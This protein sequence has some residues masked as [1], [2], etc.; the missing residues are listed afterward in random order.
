MVQT[1]S[2]PISIFRFGKVGLVEGEARTEIL[3]IFVRNIQNILLTFYL[4][5]ADWAV[6]RLCPKNMDKFLS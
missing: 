6:P 1:T 4:N 2:K 3:R 5:K